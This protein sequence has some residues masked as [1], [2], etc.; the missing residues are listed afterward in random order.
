M[1]LIYVAWFTKAETGI[2]VINVLI[3]N[4][5][6]QFVCHMRIFLF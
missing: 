1:T 5:W 6:N 2:L 3:G 4:E